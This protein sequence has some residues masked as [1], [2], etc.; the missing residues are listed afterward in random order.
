MAHERV[1]FDDALIMYV[2]AWERL[3]VAWKIVVIDQH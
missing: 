3:C 1:Q 2:C